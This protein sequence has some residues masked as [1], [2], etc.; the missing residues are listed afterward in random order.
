MLI[1]NSVCSAAFPAGR[2]KK[3]QKTKK[4]KPAPDVAGGKGESDEKSG[5][6]KR[7]A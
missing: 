7:W 1:A 2:Y 6:K 3:A 4:K 5:F